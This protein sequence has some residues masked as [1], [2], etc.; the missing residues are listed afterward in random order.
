MG[1]VKMG[2]ALSKGS[3][4]RKW[5]LHVHTPGT[6]LNDEYRISGKSIRNSDADAD[7]I[8]TKFCQMIHDSD[9]DVI[10]IT[11]YFTFN[12]YF[13]FVEEYR[14]RY[15]ESKKV[16]L[17]NLEL[18]LPNAVNN[19]GQHVN[20]H[21]LFPD[22]LTKGEAENF[23]R[24]LKLTE[25]SASG[26]KKL[27]AWD[28]V[29]SDANAVKTFSVTLEACINAVKDTFDGIRE[30]NLYDAAFLIVSG[31]KD[32]ISPGRDK[33]DQDDES[34][35]GRNSVLIDEIDLRVHG[36]FANSSSR[37]HWL[38]PT[39]RS[40]EEGKKFV[41]HPTFGGCDA[42]SFERLEEALGKTISE[43]DNQ[44]ET[45]WIKAKPTWSGLLQ[46]LAEPD[47]RV[48]IQELSPDTKE[49]YLVIDSVEFVETSEFPRRIEL[50]PGLNAIIGSRSSG[51]SS[52]LAHIAYAIS[53]DGTIDAQEDSGMEKPGPAA[54][55]PWT[56]LPEGYCH[57]NWR[58]GSQDQGYLVYVPQN[59]LNQLST[60][61]K[62]VNEYIIPA[63][64]KGNADLYESHQADQAQI[65]TLR[66]EIDSTV[67]EWFK[68]WKQIQEA[69]EAISKLPKEESLV[70][71]KLKIEGQIED[72]RKS[73]NLT[74]DD[75]KQN[76]TAQDRIKNLTEQIDRRQ[77]AIPIAE[78]LTFATESGDKSFRRELLNLEVDWQG[79]ERF[80]DE[81][82]FD[83]LNRI[84]RQAADTLLGEL[85]S[86]VGDLVADQNRSN[87][88][89]R[90]E[91]DEL[92]KTHKGLF[93]RV[94]RSSAIESE[95]KK[96]ASIESKQKELGKYK[97][98]CRKAQSDLDACAKRI[99]QKIKERIEIEQA[100]VQGFNSRVSK[101]EGKLELSLESQ[102]TTATLDSISVSIAKRGNKEVVDDDG[103]VLVDEVQSDPGTLLNGLASGKIKLL[104]NADPEMVGKTIL[105]AVP[106]FRFAAKMDGDTIG[107]FK[108]S[109]M[110]PGKQALFALTLILSDSSDAWPLL[111]DQPEDD[112]D[113]KSIYSEI[114]TFL[115]QQKRRR[116]IIMVT[117]NANLVVGADAD[118][119]IVANRNGDDRP[120]ENSQ[121]FDYLSGGLEESGKDPE[122]SFELDKLGIREHVVEIL[123]GG[124]TAF[125]KR[126]QKYNL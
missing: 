91:R 47:S 65:A 79:L 49:D 26:T 123:D 100:S 114:V 125:V 44:A 59:F 1:D 14:K 30:D 7:E 80:I 25:S 110:T 22:T 103:R 31:K 53:P 50:N 63:V 29:N 12:S 118:L 64:Q 126:R 97:K 69:D 96:L 98:E 55:H 117:H 41:S 10:G 95:R 40:S 106:E 73:A 115:K 37:D 16:F 11:D 20:F 113:S 82:K 43:G 92:T 111:I 72:L 33:G 45:T 8:W 32:G 75:L 23:L 54:G 56:S 85:G 39:K 76:K 24:N 62:K 105:K 2:R 15:P 108:E 21:M 61:P 86:A 13:K 9:V 52:L 3:E 122:A 70:R 88:E 74:K 60:Q 42:H 101:A 35:K 34:P 112:L 78:S 102:F 99:Q 18:R 87:D 93:E 83:E 19:S 17:P 28:T 66:E 71:E 67:G 94:K 89:D 6:R 57:V 81:G 120:N 51:K 104:K 77:K 46:T 36:I 68:L 119:V 48:A 4:W 107:G 38:N 121:T 116:Q 124:E 84:I 27:T 58:N 109:T 5:D 90:S